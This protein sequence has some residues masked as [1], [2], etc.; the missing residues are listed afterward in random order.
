MV[1]LTN[2]PFTDQPSSEVES[3]TRCASCDERYFLNKLTLLALFYVPLVLKPCIEKYTVGC[4]RYQLGIKAVTAKLIN[5]GY[6]VT[7]DKLIAQRIDEIVKE[8]NRVKFRLKPCF[9][10]KWNCRLWAF[11]CAYI[12]ICTGKL[13]NYD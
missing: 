8:F 1:E 10:L 13:R 3:I 5:K 11:F 2:R 6:I 7:Q 12:I 4:S 9:K